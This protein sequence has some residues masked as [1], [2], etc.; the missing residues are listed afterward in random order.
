MR[1]LRK[2]AIAVMLA[3][4]AAFLACRSSSAY[5][6]AN[7][8][9]DDVMLTVENQN[10]YD[11]DIYALSSGLATRIGTVTGG[12][13]T[14]RFVLNPTITSSSDFRLVAAPIGGNGRASSG[15]LLISPGR[16]IMFTITPSLRSS[17]A[18][19]Q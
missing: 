5:D 7:R 8:K 3:S 2:L 9:A 12:N 17:H 10:F 6:V 14:A 1:T 13:S 18:E 11:V 16:T 15:P 19:V 4:P